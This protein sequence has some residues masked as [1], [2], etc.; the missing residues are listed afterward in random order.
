MFVA[1]AQAQQVHFLSCTL[2]KYVICAGGDYTL[3]SY[4]DLLQHIGNVIFNVVF[5]YLFF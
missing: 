2:P 5:C 1:T 4:S 3:D